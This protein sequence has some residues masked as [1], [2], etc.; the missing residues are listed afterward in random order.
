MKVR[1]ALAGVVA[2]VVAL[3]VG[4]LLAG[5]FDGVP[6][7]VEAIAGGVVDLAPPF[8]KDFAVST[9]GTADKP[10]LIVGIVVVVVGAG[11]LFGSASTVSAGSVGFAILATIGALAAS[12]DGQRVGAWIG[13]GVMTLAAAGTLALLKRKEAEAVEGRRDFLRLA[14]AFAAAGGLAAFAGRSMMQAVA[15]AGAR[16]GLVLPEPVEAAGPQPASLDVDGVTSLYVPNESFYR[17]D[18]AFT[19]PSVNVDTWTLRVAGLVDKPLELTYEDLLAMPMVERDVTLAC[20]SNDVG[21]RYVGNARWLG[22]PLS[23]LFERAGVQG[24]ATQV[25]GRSVDDFTVGFPTEAV[26]DGRTAMVAVGMNGEPLPTA[27]GFPARLVVAGLYGYVSATKWLAEIE[28]TTWEAFDAYWIPRGWAKEAP[29]KLQSRIDVPRKNQEVGAGTV[30]IAG[31][32]WAPP[33]GVAAVEIKID[34]APWVEAEL[35]PS[36]GSEAWR[37]W[38]YAWEATPGSHVI[39]VRATDGDGNVQPPDRRPPR[40]DGAT[41]YHTIRVFVQEA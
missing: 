12:R 29:I 21:G 19:P 24:G 26:F 4:E 14:G 16:L 1:N 25:V 10:A 38:R 40:P 20:V 28:L 36:A 34:D 32:A 13:A 6:S 31:V 37:Q 33:I 9:L 5:I 7:L 22:V 17:I 27:H 3:G 35:G 30:P 11:A 8:L 15:T 39:S 41:G 2:A 18:T 23:D